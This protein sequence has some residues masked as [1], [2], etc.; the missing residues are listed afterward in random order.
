MLSN[1][2]RTASRV[3]LWLGVGLFALGLLLPWIVYPV[4]AMNIVVWALFAVGFNLLLGYTGL[5]SFGHAMFFGGASYVTGIAILHAHLPMPLALLAGAAYAALLALAVGALSIRRQ[6]IYFAMITLAFAQLIYF[7]VSGAFIGVTGGENG[8]QGVPRGTFFGI[9]LQHDRVMYYVLFA[10]TAAVVA[11][12]VRVIHSPFGQV[13]KAIRE[14]EQRARSL[15][16]DVDRF[17][18]MA[19]VLSG[20]VSGLAGGLLV[21]FQHFTVMDNVDWRTS[22]EVVMMTLLGGMGTVYG[23]IVGAAFYLLLSDRLA[24]LVNAPGVFI[25]GIFIVMVLV[26]RRGIVGEILA[27]RD[28]RRARARAEA[29]RIGA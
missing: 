14:N 12:V 18:L 4:L 29:E 27:R 6:G 25:G 13:L 15:G 5:L 22:G 3:E 21:V 17:K 11:F 2:P 28:A 23:P 1:G 7:F 16:Y 26:F 10:I 19:F 9:P 24:V 20:A 8:L